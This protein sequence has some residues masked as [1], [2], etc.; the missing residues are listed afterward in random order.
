[1][2]YVNSERAE[3]A[4]LLYKKAIEISPLEPDAYSNLGNL[5]QILSNYESAIE[6]SNKS[7]EL[8]PNN[9]QALI[10][11]GWSHKELG[12]LDRLLTPP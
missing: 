1:M 10:T 6:F 9:P 2:L 3:E 12:N 4:I 11:L 5:Y 8:K 7:L